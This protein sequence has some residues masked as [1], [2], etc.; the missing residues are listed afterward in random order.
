MAAHLVLPVVDRLPVRSEQQRH[1]A[2]V[3]P[4]DVKMSV[5]ERAAAR[6]PAQHVRL[7]RLEQLTDAQAAL[8][9]VALAVHLGPLL[10]RQGHLVALV[11]ALPLQTNRGSPQLALGDH[12]DVALEGHAAAGIER[13]QELASLLPQ[14]EPDA[15]HQIEPLLDPHTRPPPPP[16]EGSHAPSDHGFDAAV[17]GCLGRCLTAHGAAQE[18]E[19]GLG[20]HALGGRMEC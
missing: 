8:G 20:G 4:L 1:L 17:D 19:V 12:A 16:D 14:L 5:S 10:V 9:T 13:E 3:S 6:Q 7:H 2:R 11:A 18:R 15:L